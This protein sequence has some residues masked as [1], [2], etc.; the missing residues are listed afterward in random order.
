MVLIIKKPKN[1]GEWLPSPH[2][3]IQ[4]WFNVETIIGWD[5][6]LFHH[7]YARMPL[8]PEDLINSG[9]L[10][11]EFG[12]TMPRGNNAIS[13]KRNPDVRYWSNFVS[14]SWPS[15]SLAESSGEHYDIEWWTIPDR[16][17]MFPITQQNQLI[18][19]IPVWAFLKKRDVNVFTWIYPNPEVTIRIPVMT[20]TW[21]SYLDIQNWWAWPNHA[22]GA[23]RRE[24]RAMVITDR[25]ARL[26]LFDSAGKIISHSWESNGVTYVP[27]PY[28]I[29]VNHDGTWV[30][31]EEYFPLHYL[32]KFT[33]Q[34]L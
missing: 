33:E 8:L 17:N 27:D 16:P 32:A 25:Y 15:Y 9:R 31:E 20:G 3:E 29:G 10:F 18:W 6:Y 5:Q 14:W 23:K 4:T 22:Y 28:P 24:N 26:T 30:V 34:N 12:R 21:Y 2:L 19:P 7:T 1:T 13:G 11:L